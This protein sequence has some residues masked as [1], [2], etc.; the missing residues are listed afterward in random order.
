VQANSWVEIFVMRGVGARVKKEK[1]LMAE[2]RSCECLRAEIDDQQNTISMLSRKQLAAESLVTKVNL[3]IDTFGTEEHRLEEIEMSQQRQLA[4]L[5][6]DMAAKNSHDSER[7]RQFSQLECAYEA[8]RERE[9]RREVEADVDVALV[10]EPYIVLEVN[11]LRAAQRDRQPERPL[12]FHDEN[13]EERQYRHELHQ[14]FN[15][16][17]EQQRQSSQQHLEIHQ[18]YLD[19]EP[20]FHALRTEV[21]RERSTCVEAE[22]KAMHLELVCMQAELVRVG[23]A[24]GDAEMKVE[25]LELQLPGSSSQ[26]ATSS[27]GSWQLV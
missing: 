14:Q 9:A 3:L 2:M 25:R 7:Q 21:E 27:P 5:E 1:Q 18:Q 23:I 16:I 10:S 20:E 15:E 8:L 6:E 11:E 4:S 19:R 13:A 17:L 26:G 12:R 22:M 24:C